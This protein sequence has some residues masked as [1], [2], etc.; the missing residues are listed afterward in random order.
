MSALDWHEFYRQ[1]QTPWEDGLPWAPLERIVRELLPEGGRILDVGCGFGTQT[2]HL[3]EAGFNVH[4]IDIVDTAVRSARSDATRRNIN[5]E[6][7]VGDFFHN[8]LKGPYNLVFDRSFISNAENQLE[9]TKFAERVASV[10]TSG[11]WWI[12]V[13]GCADNR[14]PDGGP[15]TR[16]YPRLTLK[17]LVE[18]CEPR[19]QIYSVN[20]KR[21]GETSDNDF[22]AWVLVL[23]L[24]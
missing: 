8:D 17:E 3:A 21:F 16:G 5:V 2:L 9:R 12:D 20:R 1:G 14:R 13:T 24:R 23:Q 6:F 7:T 18:V 10:L 11:G 22:M 4:G 15:D 19:F